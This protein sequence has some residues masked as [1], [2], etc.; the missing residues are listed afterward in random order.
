M[1]TFYFM[2]FFITYTFFFE[3]L[4]HIIVYV[5]LSLYEDYISLFI[6]KDI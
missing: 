4:L 6:S 5:I 1:F 3:R 2:F